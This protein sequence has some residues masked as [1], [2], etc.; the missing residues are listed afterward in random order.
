MPHIYEV[1]ERFSDLLSGQAVIRLLGGD[2]ESI[3]KETGKEWDSL[4]RPREDLDEI[5]AMAS[6][7]ASGGMTVTVNVNNHFEGSA[8]L[9]I[10]RL[11]SFLQGR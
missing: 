5:A 6:D 2:R 9:T 1:Y 11:K 4:A 3:E 8:P 7:M 10:R